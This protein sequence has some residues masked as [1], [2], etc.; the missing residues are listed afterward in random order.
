ME[1]VNRNIQ[2]FCL[3]VRH[4]HVLDVDKNTIKI[5]PKSNTSVMYARGY[6]QILEQRM[7]EL[8]IT[9]G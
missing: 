6:Y 1:I 4:Y 7:S 9:Q 8:C 5:D 2:S 3:I